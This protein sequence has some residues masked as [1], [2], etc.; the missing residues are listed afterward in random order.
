MSLPLPKVSPFRVDLLKGKVALITGGSSGIGFEITRQLGLHG[1]SVVITGRRQNVI[2][3]SAAAL[4]Q[5]GIKV[6]GAQGDVRKAEDVVRWVQQTTDTFGR[7]DIL[8]NCAAGNFLASAD[9]ISPNGF[10]TVMEIDALGTFAASRAAFPALKAS[11]DAAIIN[12]TATLQYGATWWQAHASAAKSAV[13][14]LTRSLALEWGEFGI[15]TNGIAPGIVVGTPGASKL[16]GKEGSESE[17]LEAFITEIPLG[18]AQATW[19]IGITAVYLASD[20]A[21]CVNGDTIVVDGGNWLWKPQRVPRAAV[22]AAAKSA[23][24]KSRN[25]VPGAKSKL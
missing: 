10:R 14:S 6:L 15:R 21:R 17:M 1:A 16:A 3:Q 7:L 2:D 20:A 24:T 11:G 8:V 5:E 18:R 12:I 9:A 13:D 22:R 4:V 25:M 23:E 19:D